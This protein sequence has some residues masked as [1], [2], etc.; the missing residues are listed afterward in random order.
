MQSQSLVCR[1]TWEHLPSVLSFGS[2]CNTQ[3]P[4]YLFSNAHS[5]MLV[6]VHLA[7]ICSG[8]EQTPETCPSRIPGN[9]CEV[10]LALEAFAPLDSVIVMDSRPQLQLGA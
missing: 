1:G 2:P 10:C 4:F 6:W 8:L 5:Q 7:S 3:G 9:R